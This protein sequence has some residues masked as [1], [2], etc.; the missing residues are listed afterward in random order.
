MSFAR[1]GLLNA[2]QKD[3][4]QTMLTLFRLTAFEAVPDDF[5]KVLGF[6]YEKCGVEKG[7]MQWRHGSSETKEGVRGDFTMLWP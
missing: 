4:G 2:S 6:Y 3:K 1:P 5:D 7:A